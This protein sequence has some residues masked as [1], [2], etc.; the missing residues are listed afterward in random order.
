[1]K[2]LDQSYYCGASTTQIIYETIG[3]YFDRICDQYPDKD[4]LI[5]RHQGV[6]NMMRK[7]RFIYPPMN[8]MI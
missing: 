5:V 4:A 3:V 8:F 1:M 2:T 7:L 6:K